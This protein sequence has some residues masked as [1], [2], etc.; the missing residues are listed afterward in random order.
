MLCGWFPSLRGKPW[1]VVA[2]PLGVMLLLIVLVMFF[3][4]TTRVR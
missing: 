2:V 4:A 3:K 1:L